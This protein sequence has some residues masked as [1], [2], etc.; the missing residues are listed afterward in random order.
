MLESA[1]KDLVLFIKPW[2]FSVLLL[3]PHM[4]LTQRHNVS[5]FALIFLAAALEPS[6]KTKPGSGFVYGVTWTWPRRINLFRPA[7][8]CSDRSQAQGQQ[9][10]PHVLT[11]GKKRKKKKSQVSFNQRPESRRR[12]IDFFSPL[13][14]FTEMAK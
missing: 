7:V 14:Q 12:Q 5:G 9:M 6:P 11:R 13:F 3:L 1:A 10:Q 4:R 2:L 8:P